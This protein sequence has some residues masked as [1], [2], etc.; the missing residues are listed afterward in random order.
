M[1]RLSNPPDLLETLSAQGFAGP[2]D[3]R[4]KNSNPARRSPGPSKPAGRTNPGQ[5]S[6]PRRLSVQRRRTSV[7]VDEL[8][9]GYHAGRS[10]LDLAMPATSMRGRDSPAPVCSSAPRGT[11]ESTIG[12]SKTSPGK[13]SGSAH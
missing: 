6:N 7:D 4:H 5:V 11:P 9:I 1:G 2:A 8:V 10:L 13:D 3:E 12:L